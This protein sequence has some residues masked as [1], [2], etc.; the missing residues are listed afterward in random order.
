MTPVGP[1]G[2]IRRHTFDVTHAGCPQSGV[3]PDID[4]D[5]AVRVATVE[6]RGLDIRLCAPG[7]L[8]TA[9]RVAHCC[10]IVYISPDQD[11]HGV[12]VS[13]IDAAHALRHHQIPDWDI[14]PTPDCHHDDDELAARRSRRSS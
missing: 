5:L 10:Q 2:R 4:Y 11:L 1:T 3:A 7:E 8:P 12:I 9:W 13:A 6:L 14:F